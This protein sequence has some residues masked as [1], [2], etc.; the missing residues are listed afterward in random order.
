[1]S[2]LMHLLVLGAFWRLFAL[3]VMGQMLVLMHLLVLGAFW[4]PGV[5]YPL[6]SGE[7]LRR[8]ASGRKSIPP[9]SKHKG[10]IS[11]YSLE[12]LALPQTRSGDAF[13]SEIAAVTGVSISHST[14]HL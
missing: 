13:A 6:R 2:V 14:S 9:T 8:I 12:M 1:M 7:T 10:R 4:L 11:D 5:S 3:A